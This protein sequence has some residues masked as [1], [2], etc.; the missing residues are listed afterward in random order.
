M[1]LNRNCIALLTVLCTLI[2]SSSYAQTTIWSD[3]FNSYANSVVNGT[4]TGIAPAD[5]NSGNNVVINSSRIET[6]NSCANGFWRTQ[7]INGTGFTAIE[8]SFTTGTNSIEGSDRFSFRYRL[9]GGSRI[10]SS[11]IWFRLEIP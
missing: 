1:Y 6:G 11:M 7:P 3:D 9:D 10:M 5:W 8:L 4:G 2:F